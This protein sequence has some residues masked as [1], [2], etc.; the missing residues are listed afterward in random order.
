VSSLRK[1][2]ATRSVVLTALSISWLVGIVCSAQA[3]EAGDIVTFIVPDSSIPTEFPSTKVVFTGWSTAMRDVRP[4]CGF[5]DD[6]YPV[7]PVVIIAPE[8]GWRA[9]HVDA[10][11]MS[12]TTPVKP[13]TRL[14]QFQ[15]IGNCVVGTD[16]YRKYSG[17]VD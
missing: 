5:T 6:A 2:I 12:Q 16:P 4:T 14:S 13:G 15:F 10:I 9:F 7:Q 1:S 17:V 8:A 3:Q 11:V